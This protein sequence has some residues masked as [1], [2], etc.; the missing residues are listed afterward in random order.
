ML[1]SCDLSSE[2]TVLFANPDHITLL[3]LLTAF[4]TLALVNLSA[5]SAV[6]Q[7]DPM[8]VFMDQEEGNRGAQPG[9]SH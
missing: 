9:R 4:A 6:I 2:K 8:I 5:L 1:E 3:T 7:V